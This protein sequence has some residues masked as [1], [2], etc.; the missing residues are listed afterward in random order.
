M[1]F[2]ENIKTIPAL[3]SPFISLKAFAQGMGAVA[4]IYTLLLGY[5]LLNNNTAQKEIE[6]RLAKTHVEVTYA[7]DHTQGDVI[8][9]EDRHKNAEHADPQAIRLST[10]PIPGI[11]EAHKDGGYLPRVSPDG[12]TPFTGYQRPFTYAGNPVIAVA[13]Q[14]L[15]LS[16]TA[17]EKALQTL[18]PD[19]T[20]ILSPYG[21]HTDN[22]QKQARR[23]GH[24]TWLFVP[25]QTQDYPRVDTGPLTL[26]SQNSLRENRKRLHNVLRTATG[27][28]GVTLFTDNSFINSSTIIRDFLNDLSR[29]GLGIV[30]LNPGSNSIAQ[31]V[32]HESA[33][34]Y[35]RI[36]GESTSMS[37]KTAERIAKDHGLARIVVPLEPARIEALKLWLDTLPAKNIDLAPLSATMTPPQPA[38]P[39]KQTDLYAPIK[40]H[41]STHTQKNNTHPEA[42]HDG[43]H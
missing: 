40:N 10:A 12:L 30:D 39:P 17:S 14:D 5:I 27:Y 25:V 6:S 20:F 29:R 19:I 11:F 31:S 24:E 9:N 22:W 7:D 41:A 21:D 8:K 35:E 34:A 3:I 1:Q 28:T 36:N 38:L 33:G 4:L 37:F 23:A 43:H 13:I 16:E 42:H 18:P 2:V 15:G 26:L 32:I